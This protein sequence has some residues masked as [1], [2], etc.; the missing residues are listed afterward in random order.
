[1]GDPFTRIPMGTGPQTPALRPGLALLR[2]SAI[3]SRRP[4]VWV[5][6]PQFAELAHS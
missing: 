5:I 2:I 1:M 3:L 4:T 6:R